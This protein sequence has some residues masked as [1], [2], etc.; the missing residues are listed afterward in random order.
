MN[1][2]TNFTLNIVPPVKT[3]L[4]NQSTCLEL[5]LQQEKEY[6]FEFVWFFIIGWIFSQMPYFL[7]NLKIDT[8]IKT[9]IIIGLK[10][11]GY[12]LNLAGI[13]YFLLVII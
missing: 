1:N 9:R 7:I 6:Y 3:F 8:E 11:S 5:C 13:L 2:F 12:I 10:I 4:L